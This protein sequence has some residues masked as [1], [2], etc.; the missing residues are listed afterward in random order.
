MAL[1]SGHAHGDSWCAKNEVASNVTMWQVSRECVCQQACHND[2]PTACSFQGHSGHGGYITPN[3]KIR[4]G[5]IFD[6]D[7]RDLRAAQPGTK[8]WNICE[9]SR[10]GVDRSH[11][12][13]LN[14]LCHDV[15]EDG[16]V[17]G[18]ESLGPDF[19]TP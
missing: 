14:T 10:E 8:T 15:D 18:V 3:T 19:Y 6:L 17:A 7:L 11:E 2:L 5:R 9:W 12:T 13:V 16:S 1:T 4:N